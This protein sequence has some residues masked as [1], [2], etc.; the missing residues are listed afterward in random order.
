M[1]TPLSLE[2]VTTCGFPSCPSGGQPAAFDH[3]QLLLWGELRAEVVCV[4]APTRGELGAGP[5]GAWVLGMFCLQPTRL[6]AAVCRSGSARPPGLV[7]KKGETVIPSSPPVLCYPCPANVQQ[8]LLGQLM[9]NPANHT[10]LRLEYSF[11]SQWASQLAPV[12]K[13]PPANVPRGFPDGPASVGDV[14]DAGLIPG[15]GR[16][17]GGGNGNP[18]QYSWLENSMDRGAWRSPWGCKCQARFSH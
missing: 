14:R 2:R 5:L 7:Q 15:S 6:T 12:V 17:P 13:N 9:V 16:S 1:V 8:G 18:L 10:F 11:R 3:K 4:N